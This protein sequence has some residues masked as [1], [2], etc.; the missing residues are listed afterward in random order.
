MED[1]AQSHS[2]KWWKQIKR[3]TGQVSDKSSEW[4][5]RFIGPDQFHDCLALANG[6]NDFFLSHSFRPLIH[7]A[8]NH[9]AIPPIFFQSEREALKD[10]ITYH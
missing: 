3:L 6:I 7:T 9:A 4:F 5:H 2:A 8:V 10:L 1:L